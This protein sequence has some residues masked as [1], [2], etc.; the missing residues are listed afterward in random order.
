VDLHAEGSSI[1]PGSS[2]LGRPDN[3]DRQARQIFFWQYEPKFGDVVVDVGAG[4]GTE[5]FAYA[6]RIGASGRV[7]ALEAHPATFSRLADLYDLNRGAAI[8]GAVSLECLAASDQGGTVLISDT[9]NDQE[10]SLVSSGG[11]PTKAVTLDSFVAAKGIER[12]DLLK[13]NIEGAER[14][15]LTAASHALSITQ[16]AVI[17]C[18]DFLF[19]TTGDPYFR[20]KA[21]VRPL[22]ESAG[23]AV[24]D[25]ADATG[26]WQRDYLYATRSQHA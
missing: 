17:S 13:M 12:I 4:I 11:I 9:P 2:W 26:G 14:A 5:L 15:A 20:T 21:Y 16:N 19:D 3:W 24:R 22:L 25:R 1:R 6:D 18:H 7:Y 23:F 8:Q 10:N